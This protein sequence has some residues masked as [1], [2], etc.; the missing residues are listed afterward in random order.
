MKYPAQEKLEVIRLVEQSHLGVKGTLS[1][2]GVSRTTFYRWYDLY[3][4]LRRARAER[5]PLRT[6]SRV[7]P[8]S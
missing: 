6:G 1:N 8:H 2:I 3:A 5:P 4:P 7:E